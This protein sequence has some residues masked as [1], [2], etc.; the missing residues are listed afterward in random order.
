MKWKCNT[1]TCGH[2]FDLDMTGQELKENGCPECP[3]CHDKYNG[4]YRYGM[5]IGEREEDQKFKTGEKVF[6]TKDGEDYTGKVVGFEDKRKYNLKCYTVKVLL[7][8]KGGE[9]TWQDSEVAQFKK[10]LYEEEL[11]T[12]KLKKKA[13][14]IVFTNKATNRSLRLA[15]KDG[16]T[17]Y[18]ISGNLGLGSLTLETESDGKGNTVK[19]TP[20]EALY[21]FKDSN[22]KD[23]EHVMYLC[24]EIAK[25][26]KEL[27]KEEQENRGLREELRMARQ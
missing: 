5:T 4:S 25:V 27:Y 26:S 21:R 12:V 7:V 2:V 3:K 23:F 6:W 1:F 24:E 11:S 16:R 15:A 14:S 19:I 13:P 17:Y 10:I 20:E 8:Q 9:V 18:E 22:L